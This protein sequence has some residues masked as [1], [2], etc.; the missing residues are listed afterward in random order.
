MP[1]R[2]CLN[3]TYTL[4]RSC[5]RPRRLHWLLRFHPA[6]SLPT[7]SSSL[8]VPKLLLVR[9]NV[10]WIVKIQS[11]RE[12]DLD[13]VHFDDAIFFAQHKNWRNHRL[14]LQ[15]NKS[16]IF[17]FVIL[18]FKV[19]LWLPREM[20]FSYHDLHDCPIFAKVT[21]GM[22]G[23]LLLRWFSQNFAEEQSM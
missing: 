12:Q 4:G 6:R 1:W 19:S 20:L 22:Q 17:I 5:I 7:F 21:N 9:D 18:L 23:A 14:Q 2:Y 3:S 15:T 10:F 11:A 13:L 8:R 16:K